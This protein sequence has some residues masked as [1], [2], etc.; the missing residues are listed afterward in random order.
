VGGAEDGRREGIVRSA[1]QYK[2][3]H[4]EET[5]RNFVNTNIR[6]REKPVYGNKKK[7]TA[8]ETRKK[9]ISSHR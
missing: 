7:R 2:A 3:D 8:L 6:K 5:I 4:T 1:G 9:E